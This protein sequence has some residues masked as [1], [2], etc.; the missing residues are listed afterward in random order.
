MWQDL[1]KNPYSTS[2]F[3]PIP[4]KKLCPR[5]LVLWR[6][7]IQLLRKVSVKARQVIPIAEQRP[8]LHFS[9][10]TEGALKRKLL[11]LQGSIQKLLMHILNFVYTEILKSPNGCSCLSALCCS[12]GHVRLRMKSGHLRRSR[13]Y[14]VQATFLPQLLRYGLW[15]V[16]GVQL[17]MKC[18][19]TTIN[20]YLYTIL[21][22]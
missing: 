20:R 1:F 13:I 19:V 3:L 17:T 6:S 7:K 16:K 11:Q 12:P 8:F 4:S 9:V 2:F 18:A 15:T 21:F 10:A 14:A 22:I 5:C